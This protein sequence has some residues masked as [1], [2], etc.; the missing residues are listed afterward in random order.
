MKYPFASLKEIKDLINQLEE[1]GKSIHKLQKTLETE[2]DELQA[3][4]EKTS[5]EVPVLQM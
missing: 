4:L 2:K 5:L 3:P 1:G